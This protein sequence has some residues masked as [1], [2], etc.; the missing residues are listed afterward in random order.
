[1]GKVVYT[2]GT[3]L[4]PTSF[5]DVF[6][7]HRKDSEWWYCT[8]YLESEEGHLFSYQFTLAN[9][10]IAGIRFHLFI[11]A[12]T[13]FESGKH[14]NYQTPIFFNKGLTTTQDKLIVK[15]QTEV[16]FKENKYAKMGS[17]SMKMH[18][19]DF[20]L[21]V[22]MEATKPPVWHCDNGVL[23]MGIQN[24]DKERTYYYSYTNLE[25]TGHLVLE[26]KEYHNLKGKTWFDREGGTYSLTK[27]ECNWEWFSLRFFDNHEVMLFA[28]PQDNYYD[29]TFINTDGTYERC[30]DYEFEATSY[31]EVKKMKFS[32]NWKVKVKGEEY[33]LRPKADGMFNIFFFELLSDI[34]D[35]EG[36]VV[37]YAFCEVLPGVRQKNSIKGAFAKK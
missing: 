6:L 12:V 13:D 18:E 23:Q 30:N 5:E 35:S 32:N 7:S 33:T 16:T 2:K 36:N 22:E 20:D 31:T 14:Y 24:N 28:F 29:G 21:E 1:M 27:P 8:G 19:K 17:I 25:T 3:G 26:G 15:G 34:V 4:P 10:K 11:S 9:V 37:G